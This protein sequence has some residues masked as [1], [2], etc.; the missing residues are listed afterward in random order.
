MEGGALL[1]SSRKVYSIETIEKK[2]TQYPFRILSS[3]FMLQAAVGRRI[4][5][6]LL[7]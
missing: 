5:D 6:L 3:N 2:E 7:N 1:I 4:N